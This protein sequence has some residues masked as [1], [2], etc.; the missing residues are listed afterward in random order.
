MKGAAPQKRGASDLPSRIGA[1][2]YGGLA[3]ARVFRFAL[4]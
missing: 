2:Q 1:T 4:S 3:K